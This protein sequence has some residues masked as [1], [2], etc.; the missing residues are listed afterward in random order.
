MRAL[1][2][3]WRGK[4]KPTNVLSFPAVAA[5]RLAGARLLGD[6]VVALRDA[7]R[8]RRR[9]RASR[10]PIISAIWSSTASCISSAIDHE[11]PAEAEAMEALECAR[12]RGSASPTPTPARELEATTP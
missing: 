4:D 9:R 7:S 8:A 11:T 6:I 3:Q 12:W 1:N 10:S 2:A 5:D